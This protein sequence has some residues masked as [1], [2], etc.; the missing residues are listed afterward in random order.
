MKNFKEYSD[1]LS[2]KKES[3]TYTEI[4]KQKIKNQIVESIGSYEDYKIFEDAGY[5]YIMLYETEFVDLIKNKS[6]E[7]NVEWGNRI[8]QTLI[9]W[10]LQPIVTKLGIEKDTLAWYMVSWGVVEA[11]FEFKDELTKFKTRPV[12]WCNVFAKG[13]AEGVMAWATSKGLHKLLGAIGF[14]VGPSD[15]NG[16][17]GILQTGIMGWIKEGTLDVF[18]EE[19]ICEEGKLWDTFTDEATNTISNIGSG[20]IN[21]VTGI[22]KSIF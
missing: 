8:F 13:A 22:F 9:S 4:E 15:P 1:I 6:K 21:G 19:K 11:A 5:D 14:K 10:M 3:I 18:I 12:N 2:I 17:M 20:I 16:I 7:Y